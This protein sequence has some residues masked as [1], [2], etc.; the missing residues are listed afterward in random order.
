MSQLF[1]VSGFFDITT[2]MTGEQRCHITLT[3]DALVLEF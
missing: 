3:L 2:K 1:V